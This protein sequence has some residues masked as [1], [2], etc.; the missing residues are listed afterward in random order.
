[1]SEEG[2]VGTIRGD[3]AEMLDDARRPLVDRILELAAAVVPVDAPAQRIAYRQIS[4]GG[5]PDEIAGKLHLQRRAVEFRHGLARLEAEL[6]VEAKRTIVIGGLQEP[7]PGD[8]APGATLEYIEHQPTPDRLI[9]RGG[10]HCDRAHAG[11][12]AAFV[13]KVAADDFP[14]RIGYYRVEPGVRQQRP[15]QTRGDFHRREVPRKI[16]L[17][18][19]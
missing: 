10:I 8:A 2:D 14:V 5:W 6:C 1:M 18:R 11:N 16:V 19:D 12:Q 17:A 15:H 3:L 7:H 13:E 4:Q 9:L